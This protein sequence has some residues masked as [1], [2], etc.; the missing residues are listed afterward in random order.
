MTVTSCALRIQIIFSKGDTVK[1]RAHGGRLE[2]QGLAVARVNDALKLESVDIWFDPMEMFR[3][4][5]RKQKANGAE[6]GADINALSDAMKACPFAKT[7]R[8]S[9]PPA[10]GTAPNE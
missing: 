8:K 10:N 6:N 9:S 4:I 3:Q 2:V 5:A 7:A 1:I